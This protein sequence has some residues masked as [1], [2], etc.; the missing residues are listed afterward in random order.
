MAKKTLYPALGF[1]EQHFS[2]LHVMKAYKTG[3]PIAVGL[4]GVNEIMQPSHE[5]ASFD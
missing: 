3:N 2:R 5:V 1:N 4:F